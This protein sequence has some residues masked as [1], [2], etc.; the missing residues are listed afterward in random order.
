MGFQAGDRII[1]PGE[2]NVQVLTASSGNW[3]RPDG[4]RAALVECWGPGAGGGGVTGAASGLGMGGGGGAGGYC[5]KLYQA[6]EL[7]ALEAFAV[8][9][10]GAGAATGAG[11][12]SAGSSA[13]TF[14]GMTANSGSGGSGGTATTGNL[15]GGRGAGGSASGGDENYTGG[16]GNT[17]Q[18]LSGA[19]IFTGANRGGASHGMAMTLETLAVGA[20]VNASSPGCGGSGA[21]ANTP[22]RAGG[23]GAAGQIKITT[24]F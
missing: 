20:G 11:N 13:T 6:D 23:N 5:W 18:V 22:S 9:Q 7:S 8:G 19:G 24:Y 12:G 14:K 4:L 15:T 1:A 21:I 17:G 10:G 3:T 16:G 2:P